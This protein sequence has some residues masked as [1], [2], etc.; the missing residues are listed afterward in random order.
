MREIKT[1]H[2][3]HVDECYEGS[4]VDDQ[5]HG[6]GTFYFANG[7]KYVGDWINNKRQGY[8]IMY[9]ADGD[10][11]EGQFMNDKMNG[12]GTYFFKT[13]NKN[14][15]TFRNDKFVGSPVIPKGTHLNESGK[16]SP[17][18]FSTGRSVTITG[19]PTNEN[20]VYLSGNNI[21][22]LKGI[23][24]ESIF[25]TDK[26]SLALKVLN[27]RLT[28]V[29]SE[30]LKKKKSKKEETDEECE[31]TVE[32]IRKLEMNR[33]R[34]NALSRVNTESTKFNKTEGQKLE[35]VST[36]KNKERSEEKYGNKYVKGNFI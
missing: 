10:R 1:V 19:S 3:P 18:F 6:K 27:S 12:K 26:D 14:I 23:S 20:K 24:T 21:D 17:N 11:Y 36:L 2:N 4:L 7:N 28:S 29:A 22:G 30:N 33:M 32:K 16:I 5:F 8:G 13:G 31:E 34:S 25:N 35:G 15:G 9:F